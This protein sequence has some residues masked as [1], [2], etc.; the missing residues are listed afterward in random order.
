MQSLESSRPRASVVLVELPTYENILPLAS[1]YLRAIAE[2]DPDLARTHTF[3]IAS[4]PVSRTPADVGEELV[5]KGADY[6]TFSCYM[7]NIKHVRALVRQLRERLPEA[8]ILLGGPQVM[9]YASTYSEG[10]PGV[11]VCNGEGEFTFRAWLQQLRRADGDL[12]SVPGLSYWSGEELKTTDP[13]PR[14]RDLAEVPSPF[15]SGAF[16]DGEFTFAILE[17]NRGCPFSCTFCYWGAATNSKVHRFEEDRVSTELRW[18]SENGFSGLFIA[19]ANW[20]LSPR[21][22]V[23]SEEIVENRRET[24]YPLVVHMAAAK[25]RPERMAEIAEIFVRGGVMVTQPISLQTMSPTTLAAVNR[26]NIKER[27]YT[28]LQASLRDKQ[29]SSYVELIWPL[30]GE[31]YTSFRDG[32]TRLC[33]ARADT[34]IVYPQLLL[35]NTP[36]QRQQEEHGIETAEVPSDSAEA[37]VVIATN[38]VP[39]EACVQGY[40][41]VYALHSVYN[42]R[43]LFYLS[44]YLDRIGAVSYGEL[45]AGIAGHMQK[46]VDS[47][48]CEFFS[49]SIHDLANYDLLNSGKTAHY[50]LSALREDFD[51]IL[52]G[53]VTAQDWWD[54]PLAREMFEVDLVARPYIYRE[55]VRLP[56]VGFDEIEVRLLEDEPEVFEIDVTA[57]ATRVIAEL[58]PSVGGVSSAGDVTF[59][60]DHRGR[61]KMPYM[62]RRSLEHNANYCQGVVLRMREV[63]PGWQ[64]V[65][66]KESKSP[67]GVVA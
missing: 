38:S 42:L 52:A 62:A 32:L 43:G 51:E 19:D 23:F 67:A 58:E 13:A 60:I 25:N 41:L 64:Q 36:M 5:A 26:S 14:I 8:K 54:D 37:E 17:T 2:A 4:Y 44:G 56:K 28:E 50:V 22:V 39:R 29:I 6:Y 35:H 34:L 31:T 9:N 65:S 10:D 15:L 24:G 47:P 45:F 3:E 46:R 1:G 18:I 11:S 40:W 20:G 49:K 16:D 33:R 12:G 66:G 27:T 48:V 55:N 59:R 63:L 30:P 7:W 21:D 57:E 61:Q 53:F